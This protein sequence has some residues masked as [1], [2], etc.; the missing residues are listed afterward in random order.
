VQAVANAFNVT[1]NPEYRIFWGDLN[2]H[3]DLSSGMKAPGVF[4]WYGKA[5]GLIDFA[6][7]T[8][9]DRESTLE[10]VLD[11]VAFSDITK[12][13]ADEH[14]E[15]GRFIGFVGFEWTSKEYGNRLV[16]FSTPPATLPTVA[17]GIDTPAKL[18]AALPPGSVTAVAHPSGSAM[19]PAVDP[20]S[21]GSEQL[22]EIYSSLGCFEAPGSTLP[23]TRETPGAFVHDL[24]A[25]GLRV[26]VI[27]TSDTR[28]ST[29][30]NPRGFTMEDLRYAGGLTAVLA[31][32]LT[33][34]AI[35]EALRAR[36]CYATTGLR[37]LLE[38]T[39]DGAPMGSELRV[40]KGHR[41][42]LYGALG[43]TTQWVRL[44]FIG[45]EGP[46]GTLTPEGPDA[47]VI[48][49]TATTPPVEAPTWVY[50]RGVDQAGGMAWSSPVYL[51]PE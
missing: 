23:T 35:L 10:K 2:G 4:F 3:S 36:R 49:L 5:V 9:N 47:E 11:D 46:V 18:A 40:P 34:D 50:L 31:K 6:V 22:V 13:V 37:Y 21:I 33:H 20:A 27:G 15:V 44:E 51:I 42:S 17:A 43:S 41:A 48:E 39:V 30:G 29:P 26:G 8:D 19:S 32:E 16:I 1:E 28:L 45:P 24:L 14:T 38:F 25:R 7:L 12:T